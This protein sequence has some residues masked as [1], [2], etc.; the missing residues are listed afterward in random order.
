V[1]VVVLAR[2]V[3]DLATRMT[4]LDLDCGVSDRE[5]I[6]QPRLEISHDMLGIAKGAVLDHDVAAE[7]DVL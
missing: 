1:R 3:V 7:R 2:A 4:A 5:P 6:A